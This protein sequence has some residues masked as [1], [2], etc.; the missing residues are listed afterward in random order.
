MKI[1]GRETIF[2]GEHLRFVRKHFQARNREGVWETIERKDVYNRGAVIIVPLT[3]EGEFILEK[4]WRPPVE[5]AVI[6]FPAGLTD[7]EGESEEDAARRELMEETGYEA[8]KLIPV[9]PVPLCP[10]L[11]PT[12][13][14]HFFAP[15]V[16]FTGHQKMDISEEIE[17]L[18]IPR[19]EIDDFLLNLPEDVELDIRVPGILWVLE[20]KGLI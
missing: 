19:R 16:R 13:A 1:T 8:G 3:A 2:E 7:K 5:S 4:N 10:A 11:T 6:Q 17:V 20:R 15:D 12:R 9:M 18:K 14:N